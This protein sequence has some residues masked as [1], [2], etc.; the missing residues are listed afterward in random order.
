MNIVSVMAGMTIMG[1]AAP[2]IA[3]MSIQPFIAQ[4][5]AENLGIAETTAVTFAA[6][7]EGALALS[8]TPDSCN[9]NNTNGNA[10]TITCTEGEGKYVQS[11]TRAFRLNPELEEPEAGRTFSYP[12]QSNLGA[13]QCPNIDPYGVEGWWRDTYQSALGKCIPQVAW[14]RTAYLNSNPDNWL[15]DINNIRGYGDHPDY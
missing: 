3:N 12:M 15:W 11:V 8:A 4:K 9:V 14:T 2:Q 7:N 10:Y 1:V 6:A 5:R 13:H